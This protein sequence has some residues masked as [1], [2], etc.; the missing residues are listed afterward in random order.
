MTRRDFIKTTATSVGPASLES[1]GLVSGKHSSAPNILFVIC[2]ELRFPTVFPA[3]I[4][5]PGQW[6]E[7]FMPNVYELWKRGV[8]FT[9]HYTAANA[10]FPARVCLLTGLYAHQTW[11]C[12]KGSHK[13]C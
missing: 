3:G 5:S 11:L 1:A 7:K 8:K 13:R 9:G 10:C 12:R 6:F 4:N 2:D